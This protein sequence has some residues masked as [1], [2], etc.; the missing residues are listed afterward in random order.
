MK[1]KHARTASEEHDNEHNSY[2][3]LYT[4]DYLKIEEWGVNEIGGDEENYGLSG[5]PTKVKKIENIVFQ[6]KEAK[7]LSSS[8]PDIDSLMKE[9]IAS[10]TIG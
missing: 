3:P 5:S 7:K 9:L 4:M 10:H 8:L 6:A 2:L 1:F